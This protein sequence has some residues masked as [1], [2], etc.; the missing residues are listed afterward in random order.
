MPAIVTS[1]QRARR[2]VSGRDVPARKRL[3]HRAHRRWSRQLAHEALRREVDW[4]HR[5]WLTG[6]DVA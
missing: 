6:W 1:L 2:I 3:A 5:P 4:H